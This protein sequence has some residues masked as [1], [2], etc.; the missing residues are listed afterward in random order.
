MHL[1]RKR[2]ELLAHVQ[3]TNSQDNLL[4]IGK[5]LAY[6]AN[7]QGVAERFADTKLGPVGPGSI[8]ISQPQA[9]ELLGRGPRTGPEESRRPRQDR[10][11]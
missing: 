8:A 5:N 7:R 9:T 11:T 2:A 1:M 6:K 3:N 4:E 10:S